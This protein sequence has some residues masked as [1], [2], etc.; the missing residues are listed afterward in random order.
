MGIKLDPN[1]RYRYWCDD[2]APTMRPYEESEWFMTKTRIQ[3]MMERMENDAP[4]IL[5]KRLL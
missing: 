4:D 3:E 5:R 2:H 1:N